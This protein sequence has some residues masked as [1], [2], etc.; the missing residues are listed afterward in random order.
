MRMKSKCC[1]RRY[2][3]TH[4]TDPPG[5][6]KSSYIKLGIFNDFEGVTVLR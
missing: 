2:Y 4:L 1:V 3:V 6:S 5:K